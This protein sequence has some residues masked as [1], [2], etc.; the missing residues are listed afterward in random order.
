M[1]RPAL[2]GG[3]AGTQEMLD[4]R[5]AHAIVSDVETIGI[6]RINEAYDRLLKGHVRYR[7]AIDMASLKQ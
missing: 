3:I 7:F 5:A 4:F 6:Q 2:I 1:A